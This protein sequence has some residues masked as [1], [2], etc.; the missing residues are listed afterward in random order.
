MKMAPDDQADLVRLFRLAREKIDF[1]ILA[2]KKTW[3][4]ILN[5]SQRVAAGYSMPMAK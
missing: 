1:Y 5:F 4:L 2:P 3:K